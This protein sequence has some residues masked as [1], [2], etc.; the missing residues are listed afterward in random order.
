MQQQTSYNEPSIDGH[1]WVIIPNYSSESFSLTIAS[2]LYFNSILTLFYHFWVTLE[3]NWQES[4]TE[5]KC[6]FP[7]NHVANL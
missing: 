5:N 3:D 2:N 1:K 7:K 6:I 4:T